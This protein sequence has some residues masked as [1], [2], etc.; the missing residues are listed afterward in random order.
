MM[1]A[2][3]AFANDAQEAET[4]EGEIGNYN[5]TDT[6]GSHGAQGGN[7]TEI[8]LTSESSTSK[9]QGFHGSTQASLFLGM[10]NEVFYDFGEQDVE[11]VYATQ[12]GAT[13]NVSGLNSVDASAVDINWSFNSTDA[14]SAENVYTIEHEGFNATETNNGNTTFVATTNESP[15]EKSD[16]VFGGVVSNGLYEMLVPTEETET[17]HFYM[18][19]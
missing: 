8:N 6:A 14:D 17:Y 19:I 4:V 1:I 2:S 5:G 18:E 15:A 12:A 9:W 13:F 11:N 16:F 3:F 7:V 10:G